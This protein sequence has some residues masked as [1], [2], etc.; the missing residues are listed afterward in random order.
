[1]RA[2]LPSVMAPPRI[3]MDTEEERR[4]GLRI[5]DLKVVLIDDADDRGALQRILEEKGARVQAFGRGADA[6]RSLE[7]LNHPD[8][9]DILI[10]DVALPDED[11]YSVIQHVRALEEKRHTELGARTPAI[12]LTAGEDGTRALLAGFQAQLGKPVN[13][14]ELLTAVRQLAA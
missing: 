7:A 8:W 10:S 11:G 4:D 9:P 6:L 5:D 3:G 13:P 2:V 14:E 1:M 12:A